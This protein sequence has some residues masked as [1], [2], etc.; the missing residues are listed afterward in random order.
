MRSYLALLLPLTL[1]SGEPAIKKEANSPATAGH[2]KASG[3]KAR[4][5]RVK[6]VSMTSPAPGLAVP[7]QAPEKQAPEKKDE[8]A[9]APA[10]KTEKAFTGY[11][12]AG[13][14]WV[15]R[16]GD[17]NTYRSMVNLSQGLRLVGL[18]VGYEP[19]GNK[20]V[21]SLR[22]QAANWGG[23][24]YNTAR[25][26]ILKRGKY[27]YNGNY[28]N[29]AY[30]NHLP[31]FAD[32]SRATGSF[33]NQRAYDTAISNFDN[34]LQLMPGARFVPY[35]G[36]SRNS[37]LGSG[38]TPLVQNGNE[39]PLR[40]VVDWGQKEVR[41]GVRFEMRRWHATLEEGGTWF[42][43]NQSV[44][45]TQAL[46]GNRTSPYFGQQLTLAS[47][48]QSYRIRGT[49]AYTKGLITANP[50]N[51]LDLSGAF[52]RSQPQTFGELNQTQ[53]GN[54]A[55]AGSILLYARAV[56]YVYGNARGP[57]TSGTAAAEIRAGS[58]LRIRQVWET[59]RFVI[60]STATER[61]MMYPSLT[62]V[63]VLTITPDG[64]RLESTRSREQ[65]EALFDLSKNFMLRGGYRWEWG[66][67]LMK[68][69]PFVPGPEYE[70]GE[71]KRG[72]LLA[73]FM[74]RP[75][76]RLTVNGDF[77]VGD[78]EKTYYRIGLMDTTKYRLQG[79]VTLPASM[80]FNMIYTRFENQNP[81]K[82]INYDYRSQATSAQLQWMPKGG[83]RLSIL[84]DYSRSTIRSDISYLYPL[85]LFNVRSLY[86]DNANTGMLLADVRLPVAK[87][88]E[89]KLTF[90]GSLVT[91]AGSRPS[92]YYQPQGRIQLPVTPKLEFF[93]EWRYYGLSQPYFYTYEG[94]RSHMYM[95]GLRFLL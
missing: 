29:I 8:K 56:D 90:G 42:D 11:I 40:N 12:D 78:G 67:S 81:N 22:L 86:A 20:L 50:A 84:A 33:L 59:D 26:D 31:S 6:K 16:A 69:D 89:V 55:E 75:F 87:S 71:L 10:P 60:N 62:A 34:E 72:V 76:S 65:L 64:E 18:D 2:T 57:R 5:A 49:G 3:S 85:G 92:R 30:Y 21:D 80:F 82:G 45:S 77:E 37:S 27:R 79:R 25:L 93:S 48:G 32:P 91:T 9:A 43:D 23:D 19:A 4:K 38:I 73:G 24:P 17:F 28:S 88:H 70:R 95:G 39:Y 13:A 94:F 68:S 47:G 1:L 54:F 58:R 53:T 74:A 66:S 7:E 63:P 44:Y 41:G 36:F 15:G 51:W 61:S 35:F 46:T 14:R 52:V 83:K